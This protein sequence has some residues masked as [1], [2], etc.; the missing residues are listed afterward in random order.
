LDFFSSLL[1]FL[2]LGMGGLPSVGAASCA[3]NGLVPWRWPDIRC[4]GG[5]PQGRPFADNG[6]LSTFPAPSVQAP[7]MSQF[8]GVTVP[9][10]SLVG[11]KGETFGEDHS[12]LTLPAR[13]DISNHFGNVHGGAVA[14]LLDVAMASAARSLHPETG[15]VTVGMTLSYLQQRLLR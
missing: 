2:L 14:T 3:F 15:V 8:F 4:R 13:T 9:F 6:A 7:V 10:V 1:L 12:R 11:I 5:T